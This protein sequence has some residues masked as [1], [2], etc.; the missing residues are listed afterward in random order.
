MNIRPSTNEH[1]GL[2][3]VRQCKNSEKS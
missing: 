3:F 2:Y 1:L